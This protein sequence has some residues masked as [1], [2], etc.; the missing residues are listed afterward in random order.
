VIVAELP[1]SEQPER[2]DTYG[3]CK[4]AYRRRADLLRAV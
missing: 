1:L 4:P 3:D 2:E